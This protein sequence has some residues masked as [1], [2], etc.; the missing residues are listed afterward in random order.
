[1]ASGALAYGATVPVPEAY[2]A[3][4]DDETPSTYGENQLSTGPYMIENDAQG[5]AIGYEPG[6]RIHLVRNPNWD[7]SLD[8]K[9][10]YLDEIDNLEGNDDPGVASRRILDRR[11]H[12]QR[13][14]RAAAGEPQGRATTTARTSSSWSRAAAAA[15][16]R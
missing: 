6:K 13:R 9:P 4:F 15:G 16:S 2:A 1:M 10:A 12:D 14:L 3:K 7:K 5:K 11:E 8:F